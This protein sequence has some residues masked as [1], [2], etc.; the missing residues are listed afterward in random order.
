MGAFLNGLGKGLSILVRIVLWVAIF[1]LV[2]YGASHLFH[3]LH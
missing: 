1:G 2:Y 3:H